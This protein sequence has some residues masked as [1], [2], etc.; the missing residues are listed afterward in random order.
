MP[1]KKK[2]VLKSFVFILLI[3]GL[4]WNILS[5]ATTDSVISATFEMFLDILEI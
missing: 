2:T 3:I 4:S 5:A 1:K